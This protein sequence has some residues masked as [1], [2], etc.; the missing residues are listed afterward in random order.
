M[1]ASTHD[2]AMKTT[3]ASMTG[4]DTV[5]YF[6]EATQT[7]EDWDW[8][9][10]V[11]ARHPF[12]HVNVP[13]LHFRARAQGPSEDESNL[14]RSR[15]N[16]RVSIILAPFAGW[17][18]PLDEVPDDAFAK[19]MLGDGV[20]IDP[21]GPELR[22]PCDGEIISVAAARESFDRATVLALVEEES[23]LLSADHVRLQTNSRFKKNNLELTLT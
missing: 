20:A 6:H 18:A 11:A 13:V 15:N 2:N 5:G 17:C 16:R 1:A 7:S 19:A 9:L 22:A 10:R 3:G 23:G 4:T 8:L 21:T 12:G 14:I